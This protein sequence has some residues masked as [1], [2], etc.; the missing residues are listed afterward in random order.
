[1]ATPFRP[2]PCFPEKGIQCFGV[3][4]YA[5]YHCLHELEL[6][7]HCY[8]YVQPY[9]QPSSTSFPHH[10]SIHI[11]PVLKA[12]SLSFYRCTPQT[13]AVHWEWER[14]VDPDYGTSFSIEDS[15]DQVHSLPLCFSADLQGYWSVYRQWNLWSCDPPTYTKAASRP[16]Y[17]VCCCSRC[18][19]ARNVTKVRRL[20]VD[21][22]EQG[23]DHLVEI[24]RIGWLFRRSQLQELQ[25]QVDTTH[26]HRTDCSNDKFS[27]HLNFS[28]VS[29][30][31]KN[32]QID[33]SHWSPDRSST[34]EKWYRMI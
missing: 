25:R 31:Q 4:E 15:Y 20:C 21:T 24:L 1:M 30:F 7:M 34:Y 3:Q 10:S 33:P 17:T 11:R 16:P 28:S 6:V 12:K 29:D 2:L 23:S 26:T 19:V 32:S 14:R 8:G 18:K 9:E 13:I 22:R 5:T 27:T